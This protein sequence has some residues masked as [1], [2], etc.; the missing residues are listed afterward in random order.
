MTPRHIP[1]VYTLPGHNRASVDTH[2]SAVRDWATSKVLAHARRVGCRVLD[3]HGWDYTAVDDE[4]AP[5]VALVAVLAP[6]P[7]IADAV[8]AL[9]DRPAKAHREHACLLCREI[10][11]LRACDFDDDTIARR[12]ELHSGSAVRRHLDNHGGAA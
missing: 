2:L 1:M 9:R 3:I 7:T 12:L 8:Q 10:R 5:A 11:R 4:G 6:L